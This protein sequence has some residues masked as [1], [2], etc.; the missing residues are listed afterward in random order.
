MSEA[1][2]ALGSLAAQHAELERRRAANLA[3]SGQTL[4]A[5]SLGVLQEAVEGLLAA[6]LLPA[7]DLRGVQRY[8]QKIAAPIGGMGSA[9]GRQCVGASSCGNLSA[10]SAG[11]GSDLDDGCMA[12]S[13]SSS[14]GLAPSSGFLVRTSANPELIKAINPLAANSAAVS[15]VSYCA[16]AW[17][18]WSISCFCGP[19]AHDL[20]H[21]VGGLG[22]FNGD[23]CSGQGIHD[24]AAASATATAAGA[25]AAAAATA[26]YA[27]AAARAK[28]A[29]RPC[30][31]ASQLWAAAGCGA[32][33]TEQI[34]L[35]VECVHH[36]NR[37]S[38]TRSM[39]SCSRLT[40]KER[41]AQVRSTQVIQRQGGA[42]QTSLPVAPVS[43]IALAA[44]WHF[45]CPPCEPSI[46]LARNAAQAAVLPPLPFL[47]RSCST[48]LK[49]LRSE[50][51]AGRVA[52]KLM[53]DTVRCQGVSPLGPCSP[54]LSPLA[55]RPE[56]TRSSLV[57]WRFCK[58]I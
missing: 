39:N 24:G 5:D 20:H 41:R 7:R 15:Q 47:A 38:W 16:E 42:S 45:C 40:K 28:S 11:A 36:C 37:K 54:P 31:E 56:R 1:K 12:A 52:L 55:S 19:V 21:I 22:L 57:D 3:F 8:N 53:S 35:S 27:K 58:V 43:G 25:A 14:G 4:V 18:G 34:T 29:G 9:R 49:R 23:F 44:W 6:F 46:A 13:A 51:P 2:G 50:A 30:C 48:C 10:R 33:A 26:A 32:A 17:R